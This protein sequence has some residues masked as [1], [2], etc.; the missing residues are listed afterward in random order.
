MP[1]ISVIIC[2]YN[3]ADTLK[4]A[5]LSVL[6]QT[7][8]DL[9]LIIVND[10]SKDATLS[11]ATELKMKDNRVKVINKENG[12]VARARNLSLKAATGEYI[13]FCD[14]DDYIDIGAFEEMY[15]SIKENGSDMLIAGYFHETMLKNGVS[16]VEVT[17]KDAVYLSKQELFRDFIELKS[18][19]LIDAMCNKLFRRSVIAQNGLKFPEGELFE[20]TA[21]NL[22][23]LEVTPRLTVLDRCFYHYIQHIG[24]GITRKYDPR[25]LIYLTDR[26]NL[27]LKFA[28]DGD[29]AL[30]QFCHLYQLRNVYSCLSASFGAKDMSKL[31]RN[32][33]INETV[34]SGVFLECA[35]KADGV[36]L[37]NRITL[38]VAKSKSLFL[39]KLYCKGIYFAKTKAVI[40]F[41]K[42]KR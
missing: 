1:K 39:N 42:F 15:K 11:I 20:D 28:A 16:R 22:N 8:R 23:F 18:K 7:F 27:L 41:T 5:A 38:F 24:Q 35:E 40:L 10:G 12:G 21:F 25:K 17:A 37:A 3:A 14:A 36:G 26:F 30:K 29:E 32:R 19:Y 34:N 9:E 6:S 2:A 33:L 31:Q 13:T 4:K